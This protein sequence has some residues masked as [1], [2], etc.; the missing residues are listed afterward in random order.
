MNIFHITINTNM[1]KL[2][3]ILAILPTFVFAQSGRLADHGGR[4]AAGEV[5]AAGIRF[6]TVCLERADIIKYMQDFEEI[7]FMT[8]FSLRAIGDNTIGNSIVFFVNT[9][10]RTWS[11]V[12]RI[13]NV[14]CAIAVGVKLEP[15]IANAKGTKIRHM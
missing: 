10:T 5:E 4:A 3:L 8:G 12:E 11:V 14:Y 1:K 6:Q 9:E 13:D 2:L 7:P 15:F